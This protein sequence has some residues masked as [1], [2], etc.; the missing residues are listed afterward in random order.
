VSW[1]VV[2]FS[3]D[4][5]FSQLTTKKKSV[6]KE[7]QPASASRSLNTEAGKHTSVK[8]ICNCTITAPDHTHTHTHKDTCPHVHVYTRMPTQRRH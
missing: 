3:R 6:K 7:R 1:I 2:L 8:L 5:Q 4:P